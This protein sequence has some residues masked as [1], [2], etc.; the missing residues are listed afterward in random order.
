MPDRAVIHIID[1]EAGVRHSLRN[2]LE[3]RGYKARTYETAEDFVGQ[4]ISLAPGCIVLDLQMPGKTGLELQQH[5]VERGCPLPI[6]FLSGQA[7]VHAAVTAMKGGAIEFLE[8]PISNHELVAAVNRA[9]ELSFEAVERAFL[10]DTLT[11]RERD[12]HRLIEQ[13]MLNKQIASE[14]NISEKTVEFHKKNIRAKV[15]S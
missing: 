2:L 1:D 10:V 15:T 6:V 7:N 12:V 13:G 8:K 4:S 11:D 5:L 9:T 14:L 3:S